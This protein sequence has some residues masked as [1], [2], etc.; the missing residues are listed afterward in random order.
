MPADTTT[1]A[2]SANQRP[3]PLANRPLPTNSTL[4]SHSM[5]CGNLRAARR[6][7]KGDPRRQE[8]RGSSHA[9]A[10]N[11]VWGWMCRRNQVSGKTAGGGAIAMVG[12][13]GVNGAD[14]KCGDGVGAP[15]GGVAGTGTSAAQLA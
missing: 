6:G 12:P 8:R 15:A 11:T 2:T 13:G 5:Q 10:R 3:R 1:E 9:L 4:L 7:R 14:G